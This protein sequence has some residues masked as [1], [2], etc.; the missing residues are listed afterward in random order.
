MVGNVV[1]GINDLANEI[2]RFVFHWIGMS[3]WEY[4]NRVLRLN[5][6]FVEIIY[7]KSYF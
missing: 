1:I 5:E 6:A 7:G 2:V 3:L 4:A